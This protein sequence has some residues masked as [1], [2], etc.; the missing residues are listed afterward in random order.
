M[1]KTVNRL[2]KSN[3][4][5]TFATDSKTNSINIKEFNSL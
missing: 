1:L 2:T 3:K 5:L 4:M